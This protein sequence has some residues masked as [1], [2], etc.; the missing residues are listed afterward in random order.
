MSQTIESIDY[1]FGDDRSC[2]ECN[3]TIALH[4]TQG[5]LA[6]RERESVMPAGP[7]WCERTRAELRASRTLS[8]FRRTV[9]A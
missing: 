9:V 3:H 5:C 1:S 2:V 6:H 8:Q 4:S 7:C